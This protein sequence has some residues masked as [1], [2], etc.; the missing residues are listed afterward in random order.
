M[1]VYKKNTTFTRI[2]S[3]GIGNFGIDSIDQIAA[4]S[5]TDIHLVGI[6]T[7]EVLLSQSSAKTQICI[8][9]K[10]AKA[11]A[12]QRNI[13][14]KA[15]DKSNLIFIIADSGEALGCDIV[16]IV[17]KLVR[18]PEVLCVGLVMHSDQYENQHIIEWAHTS[19]ETTVQAV[20]SLLVI[21]EDTISGYAPAEIAAKVVSTFLLLLNRLGILSL[22]FSDV[23][24]LM[25]GSGYAFMGLGCAE[26]E[27]A[28]LKAACQAMDFP[29]LGRDRL[30]RATRC[31]TQINSGSALL[32]GEFQQAGIAVRDATP[33]D[34]CH[35]I[36][37]TPKKETH[38]P[39][40]VT[41][42]AMGLDNK[43][44]VEGDSPRIIPE[45]ISLKK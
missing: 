14:T 8:G 4:S 34:C 41:I 20:D 24:A 13:F 30:A 23:V 39:V 36:D 12:A 26:G 28:A 16:P 6:D 5:S 27:G 15:F 7:D 22:L 33:Y 32:F 38:A 42:I 21:P 35:I 2:T 18:K 25:R 10:T 3:C 11:I 45:G 40:E 44:P 19:L 1:N 17:S 31:I 37:V 9:S 43:V 29:L